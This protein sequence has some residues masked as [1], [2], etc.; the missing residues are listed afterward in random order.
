LESACTNR[1]ACSVNAFVNRLNAI[2]NL[3]DSLT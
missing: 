2:S 3:M 1:C